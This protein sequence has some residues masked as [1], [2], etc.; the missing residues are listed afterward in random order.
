MRSYAHDLYNSHVA[1][2]LGVIL[3]IVSSETQ[4]M[5][6]GISRAVSLHEINTRFD[7][8]PASAKPAL[9]QTFAKHKHDAAW[10]PKRDRTS[11]YILAVCEVL[12]GQDQ[13]GM[14]TR[15][16]FLLQQGEG[17]HAKWS[18]NWTQ[19]GRA[20][21]RSL[22]EAVIRDKLG[23]TAI[24]CWRIM[25]AKGKLDEKHVRGSPVLSHDASRAAPLTHLG[26]TPRRSPASPSSR[27]RK[28]AR[29]SAASL[30]R[31]SSSRKRCRARPTAPPHARSTSG[32]STLTRS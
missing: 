29:F 27:S 13:W 31:S 22:V 12:S 17:T 4:L 10:P 26:P 3:D 23:D 28:R 16:M 14:T 25:E 20:M 24:R 21:K 2:V 15:E 1:A 11:D 7:R 30:P 9:S 32:S 18:V 5:S 6:E 19:L 8:L